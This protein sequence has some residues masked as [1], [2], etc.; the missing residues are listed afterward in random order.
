MA[1]SREEIREYHRAWSA[2]NK[3]R[4]RQYVQKRRTDH[5]D[6]VRA[7]SSRSQKKHRDRVNSYKRA[8]RKANKERITQS[9]T[10]EQRINITISANIRSH[11]YG[12]KNGGHWEKLVGYT[13]EELIQHLS[14]HFVDGMSWENYGK[15]GWHIDHII[16]MSAFNFETPFDIDFKRCWSL[17]NLRPLWAEDNLKKCNKLE[18][19]MQP[20]LPIS[21]EYKL[22][23]NF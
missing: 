20:S 14:D 13:L 12:K 22:C 17:G 5:L 18:R 19:P 8:W 2:K 6:D 16:P 10:S 1:K 3:D 21:V 7:E 23:Q 15:Y 4:I 11:L 9:I